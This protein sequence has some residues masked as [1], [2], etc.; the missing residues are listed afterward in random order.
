MEVE[1]SSAE[2]EEDSSS[3]EEE[4]APSAGEPLEEPAAVEPSTSAA[5]DLSP[6]P[7]APEPAAF[8]LAIESPSVVEQAPAFEPEPAPEEAVPEVVQEEPP[9][10]MISVAPVVS[11]GQAEAPAQ[12]S[13]SCPEATVEVSA[14]PQ[15]SPPSLPEPEHPLEMDAA[16]AFSAAVCSS[17]PVVAT[18]VSEREPRPGLGMPSAGPGVPAAGLGL[19][20]ARSGLG[21][22]TGWGVGPPYLDPGLSSRPVV[23]MEPEAASW[24]VGP[25]SAS[26]EQVARHLPFPICSSVNLLLLQLLLLQLS[27]LWGHA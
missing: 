17:L 6:V 3:D 21:S 19:T 27:P 14:I 26:P 9:A 16:G 22:G 5:E 23:S 10:C 1:S 25:P 8:R 2:E 15:P 11:Q 12:G 7:A 20:S 18:G 4:E 13:G 24:T